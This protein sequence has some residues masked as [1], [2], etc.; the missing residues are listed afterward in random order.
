MEIVVTVWNSAVCFLAGLLFGRFGWRKTPETEQKR[1]PGTEERIQGERREHTEASFL[2]GEKRIVLGCS[3]GSPASGEVSCLQ[4]GNRQ[5][6]RIVPEEGKVYSPAAGKIIRLFPT[7]NA[8]LLR[9]ENGIV[10]SIR[11]GVATEALEGQ[12][13][14]SRIV[15]NEIVGK[16]KLL[17]E[18]DIDRIRE[19]G[20]DPAILL[21]L[22]EAGVH[23]EL[24][25]NCAEYVKAGEDVLQIAE[26][27]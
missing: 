17:L 8:M 7:G 18:Y 19:E 11:A 2:S 3:I 20:F 21:E 13:Y 9:L 6:L 26:V 27:L 22:E 25:V 12:Y 5:V 10:L 14:R 4:E 1:H 24:C 16:G 23:R 15:Q